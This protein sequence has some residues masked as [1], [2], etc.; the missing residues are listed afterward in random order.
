MK[1]VTG[2]QGWD[3]T[4]VNKYVCMSGLVHRELQRLSRGRVRGRGRSV[5]T[6]EWRCGQLYALLKSAIIL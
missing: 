6:H 1:S 4:Y 2:R 5:R 3:H